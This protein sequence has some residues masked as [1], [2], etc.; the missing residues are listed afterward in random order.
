MSSY[1]V[2]LDKVPGLSTLAKVSIKKYLADKQMG[3]H[4][5]PR[6]FSTTQM[7]EQGIVSANIA[8]SLK[9]ITLIFQV[10]TEYSQFKATKCTVVLAEAFS[11]GLQKDLEACMY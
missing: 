3:I 11:E 4:N 2:I 7:A 8:I 6:S 10:P 5:N 9:L 1:A